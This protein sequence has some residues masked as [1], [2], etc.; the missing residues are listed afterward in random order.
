VRF[1]FILRSKFCLDRSEKLHLF[2]FPISWKE[3]K[4]QN[5]LYRP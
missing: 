2:P 3:V 1:I 4:T 5:N